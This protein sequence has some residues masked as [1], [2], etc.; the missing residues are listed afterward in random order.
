MV[1]FFTLPLVALFAIS[2]LASPL[3]RSVAQIEA[4]I[5]TLSSQVTTLD[6]AITAFPNTGGSLIN[7]LAIHTDST[8]VI[9]TLTTANN[10]VVANAPFS[11]ADGQAILASLEAIQPRIEHALVEIV[12]KKPAFDA[13]P[14]GGIT[15]L[16]K[17]DLAQLSAATST[18]ATSALGKTPVDLVPEAT[19]FRD[20]ITA[21]FATAQAAYA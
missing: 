15:A 14:I 21:A 20:D 17:Q 7:A 12:A 1:Q 8:N 6:N 16:V 11:E 10:D 3:K 2:S 9:S 18:F 5:A 4:D 19:A 13:L